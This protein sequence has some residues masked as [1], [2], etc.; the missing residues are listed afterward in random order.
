[1][2]MTA[3]ASVLNAVSAWLRDGKRV[4]GLAALAP[5][6]RARAVI[7]NDRLHR[8]VRAARRAR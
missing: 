2:A 1:M 3:T 7:L 8:M 5:T 6:S 4:T